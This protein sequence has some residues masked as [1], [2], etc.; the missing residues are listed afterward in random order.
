MSLIAGTYDRYVWGF[1]LKPQNTDPNSKTLTLTPLF[2]YPSHLSA[3]TSLATAGSVAASG[4]SDDTIQLYDLSRSTSIG[5]LSDHSAT[6]TSLSFFTR[7]DLSVPLNLVSGD[8]D[9]S[10]CIFE[11][12]PFVLLKS[13]KPHK[14]AINDLSLHPSGKLALTVG[15]DECLAM[16][17]LV[18]GRRSFYCRLG[19]A[20]SLV[21][22]NGSGDKF[23]LAT[24]EKVTVHEAEDA[25]LV[26]EMENPKRVL[27]AEPAENGLLFTGGEDRGITA[28]DTNSGKVAYHIEDA[29]SARVKGIV[30]V[31]SSSGEVDNE[32][33][34]LVASGSSDGVIRVWDVRM[35]VKDNKPNPLAEANTKSRLICLAG[36]AVKSFK[37]PELRKRAKKMK[38]DAEVI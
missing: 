34:Y 21:D 17:N 9:G 16:I 3:I 33:P 5:S 14:K 4:G 10:F 23:Y 26:C 18:R 37:Q 12:D 1:K 24:E 28:W 30:V 22:F 29:H 19:K 25:K 20:A 35:A 13:L 31:K 32:D 6:V 15:K 11:A 8:A 7:P 38:H 27:C 36:S 2:T